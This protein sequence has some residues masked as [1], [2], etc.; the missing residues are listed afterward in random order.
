MWCRDDKG[1]RVS[2]K[3]ALQL[4]NAKSTDDGGLRLPDGRT[5]YCTLG[6]PNRYTRDVSGDDRRHVRFL[7]AA[8]YFL[9]P[10]PPASVRSYNEFSKEERQAIL[11]LRRH[12]VSTRMF[13]ERL[14]AA[15]V[16]VVLIF[17]LPIMLLAGVWISALE[18]TPLTGRWRLILLTPE[19][20]DHI[21][22][23][24][25][26]Q[27]WYKSVLNLLTTPDHPAPPVLPLEDWRWQWVTSTLRHLEEVVIE[28]A[29]RG[30]HDQHA[31]RPTTQRPPSTGYPIKPRPR[32]SS[33]LHSALPGGDRSSGQEHLELGPPYSLLLMEKKDRNAFS[34]GFGGKGA[35]GIVVYTGLLDDILRDGVQL[36]Q[37]EKPSGFWSGLFGTTV[38][39]RPR[40]SEQQT[41]HLASV[42][43]H[44]MGHLLLSHHL[45][46]LSQ[47]QVLWPSV[48]GLALDLTRAFIWPLT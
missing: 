35:G 12:W 2:Q 28:E 8:C 31:S 26:G 21:S 29:D 4:L 16:V 17:G 13:K 37:P 47:Q 30:D 14:H 33:R 43:A 41:L 20:E 27:N 40:P 10:L 48:L 1:I 34:Y 46:T 9:P 18:R 23:A 6:P 7:R 15:R 3:E 19:E 39:P 45:E 36:E 5:A 44:E 22:K 32:V 42:L 11:G 24:L 25:S 38:R